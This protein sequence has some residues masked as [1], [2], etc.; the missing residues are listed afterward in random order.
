MIANPLHNEE[1]HHCALC[2][3][4]TCG[5][6]HIICKYPHFSQ[7]RAQ[8]HSDLALLASRQQSAPVSRLLQL[9]FEHLRGH[10]WLGHCQPL[11]DTSWMCATVLPYST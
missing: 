10:L 5:L 2:A 8:A 7:D 1:L 4:P 3:H 11:S 6:A 9:L